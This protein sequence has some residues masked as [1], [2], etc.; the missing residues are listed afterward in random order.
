M[1]NIER[2]DPRYLEPQDVFYPRLQKFAYELGIVVDMVHTE[3]ADDDP[4]VEQEFTLCDFQNAW[5]M[6]QG[7]YP[8]TGP[9]CPDLAFWRDLVFFD[10]E[11]IKSPHLVPYPDK[12]IKPGSSGDE[13]FQGETYE[14]SV[15]TWVS[16]WGIPV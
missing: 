4:A 3:T 15:E 13:E 1:Y 7:K 8:T 16:G 5:L 2:D 11:D 6:E 10:I 14:G 12:E 9:T